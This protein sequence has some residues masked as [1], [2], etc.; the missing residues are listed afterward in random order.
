MNILDMFSK[1]ACSL[2]GGGSIGW[3]WT[4]YFEKKKEMGDS[5]VL[6]DMIGQP[7]KGSIPISNESHPKRICFVLYCHPSGS[8]GVLQKHLSPQ[9]PHYTFVNLLGGIG[10]YPSKWFIDPPLFPS[11]FFDIYYIAFTIRTN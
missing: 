11:V 9:F 10:A 1:E 5:R 3:S 2:D 4:E 8:S 6:V 7:V